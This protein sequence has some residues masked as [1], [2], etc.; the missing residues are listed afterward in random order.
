MLSLR[1][2]PT[3]VASDS[4]AKRSASPP[5]PVP[6]SRTVCLSSRNARS[7]RRRR[8]RS[9]RR[10]TGTA[11]RH[12]GG[13]PASS[14]RDHFAE[15]ESNVPDWSPSGPDSRG[16]GAARRRGPE[17]GDPSGAGEL[18]L[19]QLAVAGRRVCRQMLGVVRAGDEVEEAGLHQAGTLHR[20]GRDM[21][22]VDA[23][24]DRSDTQGAN[25]PSGHSSERAAVAPGRRDK[26]AY[27]PAGLTCRRFSSSTTAPCPGAFGMPPRL[28]ST[29]R[30]SLATRAFRF[31]PTTRRSARSRACAS[32][33]STQSSCTTQCS[34]ARSTA[35]SSTRGCARSW[36]RQ[37]PTRSRSSRTSTTT[38]SSAS[39]S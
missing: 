3:T 32:S 11:P 27:Y 38:A 33:T 7:R 25:R 21:R 37:R 10:T 26:A 36:P 19:L 2:S 28:A 17:S 39:P 22:A 14:T 4:R 29:W 9:A 35:T 23:G 1:S 24:N 18:A 15:K 16:R 12:A 8:S 30:R 31:G 34:A 20:A 6:A 5:R 13:A